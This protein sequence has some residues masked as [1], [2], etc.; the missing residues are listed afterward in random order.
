MYWPCQKQ[1]LTFL[2]QTEILK[3]LIIQS[4]EV[5]ELDMHGGGVCLSVSNTLRCRGRP[6]LQMDYQCGNLEFVCSEIEFSRGIHSIV[7][8]CYR[9]P[10][11]D[12]SH[13][14][15]Q[16]SSV[17]ENAYRVSDD[18]AILGDINVDL[19]SHSR[20]CTEESDSLSL[21][22]LQNLVVQ[23]T[24]LTATSATLLDVILSTQ[25]ERFSAS[26]SIDSSGLSDH[27]LVSATRLSHA[28]TTKY[29][30]KYVRSMKSFDKEN[31]MRDLQLVPWSLIDNNDDVNDMWKLGASCSWTS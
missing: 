30:I 14:V 23:P 28:Q 26:I 25:P 11:G 9:P 29:T 22:Q 31:F 17:V 20:V 18:I 15:D 12:V 4:S 24:R 3:S 2:Y 7:C 6:D 16:L 27:N 19:L 13:F 21:L 1:R 10:S 8:C 5:T